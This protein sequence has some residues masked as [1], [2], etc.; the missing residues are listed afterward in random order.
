MNWKKL[1]SDLLE[2]KYIGNYG[3]DHIPYHVLTDVKN[4][5]KISESARNITKDEN[6]NKDLDFLFK[7]LEKRKD[8]N[9]D[10]IVTLNPYGLYSSPP[11]IAAV[12]ARLELDGM[13]DYET[14]GVIV[15]KDRTI[16]CLKI[17]IEQ[18][19]NLEGISKRLNIDENNLRQKFYEYFNDDNFLNKDKKLYIPCIGG[20]SIFAFGDIKK[21]ADPNTQVCLRIH[22]AC[23][24]SDCFRGTICTCAPYLFWA[25]NEC[26]K[27]A[28]NGGV[29]FIFYNRKEGRALGEVIKFRV[30]NARKNHKCGDL[31]ENYFNQTISIAGVED[32]RHQELMPDPLLW[33]G[34]KN[35]DHLYSMSNEKYS[36]LNNV[37]IY[38]KHRHDLPCNM[39]PPDAHVEINA[40]ISSGYFSEEKKE[41]NYHEIDKNL[42]NI[43]KTREISETL[44]KH[45]KS[46]NSKY[47]KLNESK[48]ESTVNYMIKYFDDKYPK[49]NINYH[50]RLNHLYGW[51]EIVLSW[52]CDINEKLRRMI[53][54]VFISVLMDAGAGHKWSYSKNNKA[55]NRSEGLGIAVMDMFCDGL[56]SS[57][58]ALPFRVNSHKLKNLTKVDLI[59]GFQL[60]K[61]NYLVGLEGRLNILKEFGKILDENKDVFG[62]QITRPGNIID[63]MNCNIVDFNLLSNIIF[64][65]S[66]LTKDVHIH[67]ELKLYVPF[68]KLIQ[69]LLYSLIDLFN[70]FKINTINTELLTALP[71]YRNGGMIIDMEIVE[72]KD[73]NLLKINHSI[74]SDII[75]EWRCL[76]ITIIDM[77]KDKI[78]QKM[79]KNFHLG[80]I[81][82]GGTWSLGRELSLKRNG[83]PPLLILSNGTIM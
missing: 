64:K 78:N 50:S 26:V 79:N 65:L 66:P 29:G 83:L 59:K 54:L 49:S 44:F 48:I 81:L 74:N 37:G 38:A 67:N 11:T 6:V 53:D 70:K 57:D 20:I 15:N 21:L 62:D 52:D 32:A 12:Q 51:E 1:N 58:T 8:N 75:I 80:Q 55:Y 71:E 33:L 77:I 40:K 7:E 5:I 35:I 47:F 2:R 42:K 3:A 22:D 60:T 23:L 56:F 18:V 82:E 36:A 25:I 68:H 45:V 16:N 17:A 10:K 9:W 4:G 61:N 41:F 72:L 30:Y 46:G 76:T 14:D 13:I 39:I 19:W 27:T 24:N 31:A 34:I 63:S 43:S 28:Q 73:K 69:W